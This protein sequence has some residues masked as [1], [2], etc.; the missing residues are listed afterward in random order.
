MSIIGWWVIVPAC[1]ISTLSGLVQ[2]LGTSWGLVRH[3]W[4]L[5]KL[6]MTLP[7]VGLLFLHMEPTDLLA[8]ADAAAGYS[9]IK[10]Q[11]ILEAAA[12]I[13]C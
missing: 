5:I 8:T 4:V 10:S 7:S 6:A 2:S 13:L 1:L 9:D 3:Y 11:L 12:A